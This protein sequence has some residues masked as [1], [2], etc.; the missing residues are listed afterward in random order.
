MPMRYRASRSFQLAVVAF[1]LFVYI[2]AERPAT[3]KDILWATLKNGL[4]VVIV[5]NP[6]AQIVRTTDSQK[7]WIFGDLKKISTQYMQ[8]R[9][10]KPLAKGQHHPKTVVGMLLPMII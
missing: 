4:R 8:G 5:R 10:T 9:A 7:V 1:I 2:S 6:L 3:E